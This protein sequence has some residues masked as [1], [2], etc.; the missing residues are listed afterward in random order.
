M[1]RLI[2]LGIVAI[3]TTRVRAADL[4]V[5]EFVIVVFGGLRLSLS[6]VGGV[7]ELADSMGI[8]ENVAPFKPGC[9]ST[10]GAC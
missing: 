3:D 9:H 6:T 5:M 7:R 10:L 2:T 8:F 1:S 4:S